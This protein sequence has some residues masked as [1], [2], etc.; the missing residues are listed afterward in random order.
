MDS[1]TT[2]DV[3]VH[4]SVLDVPVELLPR[5]RP[6]QERSQ[7]KFDAMLSVSRQLLTEVGFE[8]FTC[9]EVASR[10]QVPIGSLYRYFANKYVIVSELNRQD[11]AA[12]GEKLKEF[13]GEVP[14]IEWLQFMNTFVDHL[15]EFWVNDRSRKEVWMAME[16]TPSTR[17]TGQIHQNEFAAIVAGMIRPLVPRTPEAKRMLMAQVLVKSVFAILNFSI[18]DGQDQQ[19]AVTELKRLMKAYLLVIETDSR[20]EF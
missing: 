20:A 10:A 18:Q 5:R 19:A 11:L 13:N 14:S 2:S 8:A 9:E 6:T 1:P 7:Q 16:S 15:S 12:V 4:T 3:R 17:L